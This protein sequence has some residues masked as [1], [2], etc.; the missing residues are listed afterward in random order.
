[1]GRYVKGPPI[2]NRSLAEIYRQNQHPE[3]RSSRPTDSYGK[4]IDKYEPKTEERR[5]HSP[6]VGPVEYRVE[7][8]NDSPEQHHLKSEGEK[9]EK[10]HKEPIPQQDLIEKMFQDKLENHPTKKREVRDRDGKIEGGSMY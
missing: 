6:K 2:R 1:M 9:R 3:Y 10:E 5:E 7:N 4:W 8:R